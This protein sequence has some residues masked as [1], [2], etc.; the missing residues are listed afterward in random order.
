MDR[1][2]SNWVINTTNF[3]NPNTQDINKCTW[4]T[5]NGSGPWF[6][7]RANWRNG[8][9]SSQTTVQTFCQIISTLHFVKNACCKTYCPLCK[10]DQNIHI[11]AP[12]A[13]AMVVLVL[14]KLEID[15]NPLLKAVVEPALKPYFCVTSRWKS[16]H[17]TYPTKPQNQT[18]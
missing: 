13:A 14:A 6:Y 11:K 1:N 16:K 3:Q 12:Q 17:L 2:S 15:D 5:N 8:N 4:G 10:Q 9:T 7:E 18:S